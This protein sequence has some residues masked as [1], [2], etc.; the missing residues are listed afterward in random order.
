[1]VRLQLD[2]LLVVRDGALELAERAERNAD[3]VVKLWNAIVELDGAAD[4]LGRKLVPSG[5]RRDDAEVMQALGMRRVARQHGLVMLP[6]A[7][8]IAALVALHAHGKQTRNLRGIPAGGLRVFFEE[9]VHE[10]RD[11]TGRFRGRT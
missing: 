7:R 8:Q 1:M 2:G 10:I 9:I 5:L 6:S 4:Q 11:R 3:V